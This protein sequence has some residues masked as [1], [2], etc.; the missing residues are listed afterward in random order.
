[1]VTSVPRQCLLVKSV[2]LHYHTYCGRKDLF[3]NSGKIAARFQANHYVRYD[4][5]RRSAAQIENNYTVP[6]Q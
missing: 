2:T 3:W 6:V 1:M 5:S 4:I